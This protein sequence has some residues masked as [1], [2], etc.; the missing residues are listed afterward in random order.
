M[1][2]RLFRNKKS[3]TDAPTAADPEPVA[4]VDLRRTERTSV[5]QSGSVTFPSG[6]RRDCAIVDRSAQGLRLR[7]AT[8]EGPPDTV[9]IRVPAYNLHAK[10]RVQWQDQTDAG[11]KLVARVQKEPGPPRG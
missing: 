7:F 10:A 6:Y 5:F 8:Y 9:E 1:L 4:P 3:E 11:L 2:S